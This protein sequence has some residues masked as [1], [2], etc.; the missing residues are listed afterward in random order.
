MRRLVIAL[1]LLVGCTD[2]ETPPTEWPACSE[3]ACTALSC[4]EHTDLCTCELADSYPT[5][6]GTR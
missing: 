3:L 4:E 1:A 2:D 6:D 5:C